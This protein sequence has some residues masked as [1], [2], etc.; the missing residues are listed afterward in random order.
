MADLKKPALA[1]A[2]SLL[3]LS[4]GVTDAAA[5]QRSVQPTGNNQGVLI[6][7]DKPDSTQIKSEQFK[8][9]QYKAPSSSQIKGEGP[10]SNQ[11]KAP[12]SNQYKAPSSNQYKGPASNQIKW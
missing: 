5:Q 11:Y 4:L 12:T 7:L 10:V 8:S 9:N 1:A 6:G 2:V 3:G